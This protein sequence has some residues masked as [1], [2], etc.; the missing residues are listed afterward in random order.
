MTYPTTLQTKAVEA[1]KPSL[2]RARKSGTA[3]NCSCDG[4]GW[5]VK[6]DRDRYS[7]PGEAGMVRYSRCVCLE[8]ALSARPLSC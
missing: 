2:N 6:L 7:S 8:E 1:M 4:G 3:Q 5:I